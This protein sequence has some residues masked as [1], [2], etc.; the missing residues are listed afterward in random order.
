MR[1]VKKALRCEEAQ[2]RRTK[3]AK[4]N[5]KVYLK[6]VTSSSDLIYRRREIRL[7]FA[8]WLESMQKESKAIVTAPRRQSLLS[9]KDFEHKNDKGEPQVETID[10][11]KK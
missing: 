1:M 7:A 5:P 11:G 9:K 2:L 3:L 10:E 8:K 6:L 4:L